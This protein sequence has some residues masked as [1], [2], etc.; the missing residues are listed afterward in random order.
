MISADPKVLILIG[1][2]L[3]LIGAGLPFLMVMQLIPSNSFLLDF[4]IFICQVV[5][6]SLGFYGAMGIVRQRRGRGDR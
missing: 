3:L 6:L 4:F 1:F 5:G 2:V